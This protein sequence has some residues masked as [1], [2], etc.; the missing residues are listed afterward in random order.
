M[1]F[2]ETDRLRLRSWR[3]D[4]LEPFAAMNAHE[5][6]ME[7]YPATYSRDE[8]DA[9]AM[10]CRLG[11]E[12]NGFGLFAVEVKSTRNFIGYVG[13]MK[14]DFPAVFTPAVEIGWRLAFH[15]WG[16]GYAA[17]AARACLAYGFTE[18]GLHEIVSFTTPGNTRSIAVMERIG[19]TG[20]LN[21]DFQHPAVPVD[22][23]LRRHVLYRIRKSQT[24]G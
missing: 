22:Y 5:K 11:L 23:P 13:L 7:F 19:M 3:D 20:D 9:F 1:I 16:R 21:G 10:R 24:S 14:A 6:V 15:A 8:S 17:E 2:L 18:V 12:A 4:D